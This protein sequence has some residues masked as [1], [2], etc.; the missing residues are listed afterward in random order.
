MMDQ[1]SSGVVSTHYF[2][3]NACTSPYQTDI[4]NAN[5]AAIGPLFADDAPFQGSTG[6]SYDF[7][8]TYISANSQSFSSS[9]TFYPA[10]GAT[11]QGVSVALSCSSGTA[12]Q[13]GPFGNQA[14]TGYLVTRSFLTRFAT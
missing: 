1:C 11:E 8:I 6:Y 5:Q 7:S 2:S 12:Q 10:Y 13:Q 14:P 3:D 9:Q 4:N